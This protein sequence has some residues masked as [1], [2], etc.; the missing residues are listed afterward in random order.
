MAETAEYRLYR[1]LA[2]WWPLISPR[3]EYEQEAAFAAGLLKLADGPA[4]EVLELGSGGGNNAS[5]LKSRFTLTLV[6]LSDDMLAVSR[7]LNPDCEHVQ[8][9]M[10]DVRLGRTFDAVFVHDAV[11][12]M[13]T[14]ADLAKA[15]E[16]AFV[17]CR[18]G[19]VAV[20]VPYDVAETFEPQTGCGGGDG[21]DG[22]AAR[23]LEWTWDPDPGD[24]WMRADFV[25][26]LRE[27]DDQVQIVH[28]SHRLCLFGRNTW[29]RLLA[30]AGFE[31]W[32][33]TEETTG[34]R[35]PRELFVGRRP[36]E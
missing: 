33:E 24:T 22:R 20:F 3:E 9:D 1:D 15:V 17:H 30:E 36:R 4:R 12:Y 7:R 6:D 25:Y 29:L 11:S 19:G 32:A 23:F 26:M 5:H 35:N 28:E 8:G 10:R 13:L 18:P 16:T 27:R 2:E 34:D 21:S 14:E 31:A